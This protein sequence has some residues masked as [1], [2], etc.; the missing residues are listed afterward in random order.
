MSAADGADAG[1]GCCGIC[2]IFV[3]SALEPWCNTKAFGGGGSNRLA[4]C[5]GSCCN[6]SFN[7][8][9][10]DKWDKGALQPETS[11][12][13]A[14]AEPMKI[15]AAEPSPSEHPPSSVDPASPAVDGSK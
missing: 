10:I 7:E 9:S 8:D 15:P 12:Q 14:P 2:S 4:G 6:K 13:P 5:C 3:F 11:T 1:A